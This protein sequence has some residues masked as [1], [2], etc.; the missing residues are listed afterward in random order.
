[1]KPIIA[2]IGRPNV[3]KSTLFNALTRTRDA[4]VA[5]TPGITRDRLF[6]D[7]RVGSRPTILVD[8]GGLAD[9]PEPLPALVS[10]QVLRAASEADGVI[11]LVDAREGFN[12]ADSAIAGK[13]RRL[14]KP[15]FLAVNKTE[16]L[17]PIQA[18]VD[19]YAL[20]MG[21]PLLISSAHG[22]GLG[23]L[24]E[25][26]L[27]PFAH[28][29]PD[30][31]GEIAAGVIRLSVI[32][33]P[34]VG[35]S[36]LINRMLGEDR[37]LVFDQP[38]TT[39]DTVATPLRRGGQDYLLIDTAGVR[40]RSHVSEGIEKLS[41]IKTLRAVERSDVALLLIDAQEAVTEQDASLLGIVLQRGRAL[42]L[43]VNKWDGLDS[44]QRRR[45][46]AE[47]ERKLRFVGFAEIHYIS[48]L[49]GSGVG[50]LFPAIERAYAS[51]VV[52]VPTPEL[53]RIVGEAV[54][55]HPPPLVR[56]RRIKLRYAH[57]GGQQPPTVV[58]HGSQTD[59]VPDS[60]RRYLENAIRK[61]LHLSGTPIR[62]AFRR[63]PNPYAQ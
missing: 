53:T 40:R 7:G 56:G 17:D 3:G 59:S 35:K 6:G 55:K 11:L 28:E 30:P 62:I 48:A 47:I 1:M 41:V 12:P 16:G 34:N 45:I 2:I 46:R 15:V 39:R 18:G 60:Y 36:T 42:V 38:G 13:L 43:A 50:M 4:L 44:S 52:R 63:A 10:Q 58:V 14:G 21:Q 9:G 32:G 26:V 24:M 25:A 57:M 31:S 49:H 23:A 51:S 27:A 5:D 37:M 61:A 54:S 33:R 29:L 8:T 22:Q 20:G 19:F